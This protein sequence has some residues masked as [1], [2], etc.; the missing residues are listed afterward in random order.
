MAYRES[1][2]FTDSI[3]S[4]E[5][6]SRKYNKCYIDTHLQVDTSTKEERCHIFQWVV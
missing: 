3:V 6:T 4:F 1:L 5:V 2:G